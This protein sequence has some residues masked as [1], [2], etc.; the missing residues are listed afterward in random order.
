MSNL[1]PLPTADLALLEH[2]ASNLDQ[3]I[4]WQDGHP[5]V[6]KPLPVA[7][8]DRLTA[9][10]TRLSQPASPKE[11]GG[12][13]AQIVATWPYG[14]QRAEAT[15]ATIWMQQLD[16]DLT[17]FPAWCISTVIKQLRRTL[18]FFPSIAEIYQ[19]CSKQMMLM[20]QRQEAIR[21]HQQE[22]EHRERA[23]AVKRAQVQREHD[24][25][26]QELTALK[27]QFGEPFASATIDD[28]RTALGQIS[29]SG[30]RSLMR[31]KTAVEANNPRC[32][33]VFTAAMRGSTS[34][35]HEDPTEYLDDELSADF[36]C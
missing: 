5:H 1:I 4:I 18:K 22:H 31:W 10:I 20:R 32:R 23:A 24:Y 2:H 7:D 34:E 29:Y 28:M 21:H 6:E 17:E 33:L 35:N 15:A 3:R 25:L 12:A 9:A 36:F 16:E 26:C 14:H 27:A 30:P 8:L 19:P 11:R 13:I